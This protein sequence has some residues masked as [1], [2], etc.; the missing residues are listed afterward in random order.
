L[1]FSLGHDPGDER[2]KMKNLINKTM[3]A[4]ILA[5]R[6]IGGSSGSN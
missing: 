2:I 1:F 5:E 4:A 6:L 3:G